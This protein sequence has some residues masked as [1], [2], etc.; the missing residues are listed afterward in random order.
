MRQRNTW[1]RAE[2]K[3][4]HWLKLGKIYLIYGKITQGVVFRNTMC[5]LFCLSQRSISIRRNKEILQG[6]QKA[7]LQ[8]VIIQT[9]ET[10]M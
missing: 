5:L 8:G 4:R 1:E 3:Q 7:E 6:E 9:G 10:E 2:K